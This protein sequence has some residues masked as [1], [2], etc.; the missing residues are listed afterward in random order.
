[1]HYLYSLNLDI[2]GNCTFVSFV[3]INRA[4]ATPCD[5]QNREKQMA[6]L[7]ILGAET[8]RRKQGHEPAINIPALGKRERARKLIQAAGVEFGEKH[9][10]CGNMCNARIAVSYIIHCVHVGKLVFL[11]SKQNICAPL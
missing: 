1:M 3:G 2:C 8:R 6:P 4:N 11:Y 7:S 10:T 9:T 5:M